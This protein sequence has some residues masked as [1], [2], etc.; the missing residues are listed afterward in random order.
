M[1]MQKKKLPIKCQIQT[2]NAKPVSNNRPIRSLQDKK[3]F[4]KLICDLERKGI[5]EESKS[6]WLN[7]VVLVRKKTGDLRFCLDLRALNELVEL[8]KFEIP[9]I[10]EIIMQL[11]DV[12]NYTLIDLK[13]AYFQVEISEEYKQK[14]AFYSGNRLMQFVRMP[15]GYKNA[16]VIFQRAMNLIFND[17][18]NNGVMIYIDDILIYGKTKMEHDENL[19]YVTKIIEE[20]DLEVNISKKIECAEEVNFLV[21]ELVTI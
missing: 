18:I 4:Q 19:K 2:G 17:K 21:I 8:D 1:N 13:D 5:V 9:R 6:L 14:T 16:P 15:R 12:R 7:P 3:D 10:Q 11:R 20:Y